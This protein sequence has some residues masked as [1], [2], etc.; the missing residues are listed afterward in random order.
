[1][2]DMVLFQI[3]HVR[4]TLHSSISSSIV[5]VDT[6][7]VPLFID[8]NMQLIF[9]SLIKSRVQRDTDARRLLIA[10]T[11]TTATRQSPTAATRDNQLD[12]STNPTRHMSDSSYVIAALLDKMLNSD[13]DI[14]FMAMTDIGVELSKSSDHSQH[15]QPSMTEHVE[16]KVVAAILKAV[17]LVILQRL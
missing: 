16:K 13:S 14:R 15:Q 2:Y 12:Y 6:P 5:S 10:T 11:T 4:I 9:T 7:C 8:M 17:C 3:K 1:M